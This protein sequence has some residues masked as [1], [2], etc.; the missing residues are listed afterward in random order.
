MNIKI[1][2]KSFE[3]I[4]K[5]NKIYRKTN[6]FLLVFILLFFFP[7]FWVADFVKF[8]KNPPNKM[9]K[10]C[11]NYSSIHPMCYG[12]DH[13]FGYSITIFISV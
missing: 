13:F 5:I 8:K 1:A 3:A 6:L 10:K 12:I 2:H 11:H 4:L 7:K 9:F